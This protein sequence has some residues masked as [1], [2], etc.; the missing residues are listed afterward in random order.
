VKVRAELESDAQLIS[1]SLGHPELFGEIFDRHAEQLLRFFV[2]RVGSADA[3]GLVGDVF[4]IAFERRSDYDCGHASACPWLYGIGSNLLRTRRRTQARG[5][6]AAPKLIAGSQGH[7]EEEGFLNARLV[8]PKLADAIEVLPEGDR[9]A[10]LLFAL[11]ELGYAEIAIALEIPI[12]TV[13]SRINRARRKLR[14][15]IP[16]EG[17]S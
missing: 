16:E 10:L 4:R 7:R 17:R 9:A 1:A 2:R 5:L 6:R 14:E 15:L 3:G 8:L 12:G 11:E 13:R